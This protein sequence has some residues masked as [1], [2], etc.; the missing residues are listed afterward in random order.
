MS[1]RGRLALGS[2]IAV[3]IAVIGGSAAAYALVRTELRQE[4]DRDLQARVGPLGS[5]ERIPVRDEPFLPRP[6]FGGPAGIVQIVSS[7]GVVLRAAEVALPATGAGLAVARGERDHAFED[8]TVQGTRLR[9]LSA[10]FRLFGTQAAVQVAR[11]LDE[12][13][14]VLD[15]LRIALLFVVL[16]GIG[17]ATVLGLVVSGAAIGPLR[18]LTRAAEDVA[19]T[20]DL[21]RRVGIS[22]NDEIGRL[23]ARFDAMLEAL[24]ESERARSQ[25]V[26]D[27]SHELRTPVAAVRTNLELLER[28]PELPLVERAAALRTAREQ[29]EELS[30]LVTDIVELAREGTEP[31]LE[32]EPIRLDE[33]VGAAVEQAR[34]AWPG[35]TFAL[36]TDACVVDGVRPRIHR[37]VAN[38]LDN[39]AKW[40]P[41]GATVEVTERDGEIT[42]RDHGPGIDPAD[43]PHV[44]ERFYRSAAARGLP[45]SGLGLAIVQ[46]VAELHGGVASAEEA[47]GGGALMRLRLLPHP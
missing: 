40:S 7:E 43:R 6:R 34:H 9:M 31:Q 35:L 30:L 8:V 14:S 17:L 11:P 39:A 2:A 33:L 26:A 32:R 18:R 37:A 1:F 46:Q 4:I 42:V 10:P 25:L 23:G 19:E 45:G 5:F 36:D 15:R 38:L 13:D 47:P 28:H 44:F 22:G 3:A 41:P 16:G 12:V 24:A 21:T 27:A 29:L 20:R